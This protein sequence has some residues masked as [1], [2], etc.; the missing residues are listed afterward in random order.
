MADAV[1]NGAWT[2]GAGSGDRR[3]GATSRGAIYGYVHARASAPSGGSAPP[4]FP[5]GNRAIL[6]KVRAGSATMISR[7]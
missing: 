3:A 5:A 4:G 2:I 6:R 7:G 1:W